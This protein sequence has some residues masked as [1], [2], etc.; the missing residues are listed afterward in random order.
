MMQSGFDNHH[1]LSLIDETAIKRVQSYINE[2][3]QFLDSIDCH[4]KNM[5]QRQEQFNFLP[6]HYIALMNKQNFVHVRSPIQNSLF[7]LN[8]RAFS[9]LLK[10]LI[11]TAL[12]NFGRDQNGFRYPNLIHDFAVYIYMM[13][14]KANYEILSA[15]LPLPSVVTI[16]MNFDENNM[17]KR[18]LLEI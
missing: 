18:M 13:G 1:S 4:H 12:K 16:S 14:G 15:N 9:P 2:N 6:A 5:Y 7:L 3:R 10:A 11:E 8:N 17:K